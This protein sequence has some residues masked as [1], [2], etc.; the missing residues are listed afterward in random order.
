MATLR[1]TLA[2]ATLLAAAHVLLTF[3]WDPNRSSALPQLEKS[4]RITFKDSE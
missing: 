4:C 1:P 2:A 3:Q